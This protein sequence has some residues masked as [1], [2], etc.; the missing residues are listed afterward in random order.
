LECDYK[1]AA[2][3]LRNNPWF[4]HKKYAVQPLNDDEDFYFLIESKVG[5]SKHVRQTL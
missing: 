2:L 5:L 3:A 4:F 1:G